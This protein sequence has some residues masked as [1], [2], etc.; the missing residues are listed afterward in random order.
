MWPL[1][2]RVMRMKTYILAATALLVPM[3]GDACSRFPR[4]TD[5]QLFSEAESVFIAKVVTTRLKHHTQSECE[6]EGI[7][8]ERC[9][10]VEATYTLTH[11]I[12]GAPATQGIVKD[13][14][15]GPLNC[16]LGVFPGWYYVFY[17]DPE[18]ASVLHLNGSFPL[19]PEPDEQTIDGA[20]S[21]KNPP[22][23]RPDVGA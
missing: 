20:L 1:S 4:P 23:T 5:A 16:S 19:G 22:H 6:S 15:F 12:K 9:V 3:S 18:N 8:S 21:I 10:Y 13:A 11:T 7:E 17:V 2:S 14:V